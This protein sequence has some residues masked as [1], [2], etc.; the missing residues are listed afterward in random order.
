MIERLKGKTAV[1]AMASLIA[2]L[3]VGGIA[4]GQSLGNATSPQ[5]ATGTAEAQQQGNAKGGSAAVPGSFLA[6]EDSG[7]DR[8][9]PPD[10]GDEQA[11]SRTDNETD[12]G[13][14]ERP[15]SKADDGR[16][17]RAYAPGN[18]IA[19]NRAEG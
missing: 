7:S 19:G 4:V 1:A 11:G 5:Q 9:E 13:S 3:G 10:Q 2:A 8:G 18:P 15:G 16:S 12:G 14:G 6:G 17:G